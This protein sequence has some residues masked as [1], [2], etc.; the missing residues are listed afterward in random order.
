MRRLA[1]QAGVS[2]RMHQAAAQGELRGDTE[3]AQLGLGLATES[4]IG[5]D[6]V[7]AEGWQVFASETENADLFW[8]ARGSGPGFFCRGFALSPEAPSKAKV[9]GHKNAD[10]SPGAS[11]RSVSLGEGNWPVCRSTSRISAADD[12]EGSRPVQARH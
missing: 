8:A 11:R 7:L 10:P 1:E 12:T 6:L 5:L 9:H 3:T 4:V 2:L